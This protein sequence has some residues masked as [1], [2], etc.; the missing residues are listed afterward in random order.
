MKSDQR[1][2]NLLLENVRSYH[3][4]QM[5]GKCNFVMFRSSFVFLMT[6][7]VPDG[8]TQLLNLTHVYLNDAFLDRLP[9]N[10][11]R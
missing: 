8:F 10:F 3:Y 1:G 4:Q 11:G 7:R 2:F 6:F 5:S 9:S